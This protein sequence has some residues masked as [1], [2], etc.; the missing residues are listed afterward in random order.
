M[1][2]VEVQEHLDLLHDNLRCKPMSPAFTERFGVLK[3][4]IDSRNYSPSPRTMSAPCYVSDLGVRKFLDPSVFYKSHI[5][6]AELKRISES[7]LSNFVRESNIYHLKRVIDAV[8][9]FF[10]DYDAVY[11]VICERKSDIVDANDYTLLIYCGTVAAA[12]RDRGCLEYF[13]A[14]ERVASNCTDSYAAAHR[15]A[16]FE[17]KRMEDPRSGLSRLA[18]A[19]DK[20]LNQD[21]SCRLLDE[22]LMYNLM[23]LAYMKMGDFRVGES[24]EHSA[25]RFICIENYGSKFDVDTLSRAGRYRSQVAINRAQL[26]VQENK[27]KEAR[28]TLFDNVKFARDCSYEY[29]PEAL[30]EYSY[31]AY[32]DGQYL[33]ALEVAEEAF[34]RLQQIGSLRAVRSIREILVACFYRLGLHDKAKRLAEILEVDPLGVKGI[35]GF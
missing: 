33:Q 15:A 26:Q 4:V 7:S 3:N 10:G 20:Y 25:D 32:L 31:V 27:P 9:L 28:A 35:C 2:S 30:A 11:K 6:I 16:A 17:I 34:W 24:I 8:V 22:G 18:S 29:L 1:Y 23:A 19:R 13:D 21:N 12:C 14:A 5:Q